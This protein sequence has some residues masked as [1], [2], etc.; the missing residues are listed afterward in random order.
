MRK[1]S[2]KVT[3]N[4][5]LLA[6][7][8]SYKQ[9][10]RKGAVKV[11]LVY[12]NSYEA[13]M[14]SLGFQTLFA[15]INDLENISCERAFY[16]KKPG[17]TVSLESE[18]KLSV[19][20]IV[21]FSISFENDFVNLV[22]LL[23]DAGIPLRSSG[24]SKF[25]PLVIAG[26][27]SCFLNPEPIAP[28][29]DCIL[30]GEAETYLE[31]FFNIYIES[32]SKKDVLKGLAEKLP[33][34]YI[35]SFYE[36]IQVD[37]KYLSSPKPKFSFA[38]PK[39]KVGYVDNLNNYKTTSTI[40]TRNT[41]FK[42][43]FLIETARGCPHGC[44]FCSAGFIYRPPRFYSK[45]NIMESIEKGSQLTK[46]IGFV[47]AAVSD[48][49]DINEICEKALE[50]ELL[51]SFSSFRADLLSKNVLSSIGKSSIKTATIAPEAGSQRMRDIINKNI[52]ED[53]I[54]KCTDYLVDAGI[55]NLKLYFLIG[56]PFETDKDIDE[57]IILIK[58]IK[59][60]FLNASKKKKKIG[61]IS[62]SINPFI[63]K[64]STPFQWHGFTRDK[65][66]KNRM[67]LIKDSLRKVPNVVVKMESLKQSK[68]NSF[69]SRA[70]RRGSD[71]IELAYKQGWAK[72][73]QKNDDYV[74]SVIYET[75]PIDSD[76]PWDIV[77]TGLK[78]SFLINEYKRAEQA[79]TTLP[80][81]IKDCHE[82]KICK[83]TH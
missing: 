77:D 28:F 69:L 74:N 38:D 48:H 42:D 16:N 11:C 53:E 18:T 35:P 81:P 13:G 39:I 59:E 47:S 32:N 82:C 8:Q 80:C 27:F 44:R 70:D 61:T 6:T 54:L 4:R 33:F 25:H 15:L 55:I 66:L 46:K 50:L 40:L 37:Q 83:E 21:A 36:T 41:S 17:S 34:A 73:L 57:I 45:E 9:I 30:F 3:N 12:P 71:Y 63:P 68:I 5:D 52:S 51:P 60:V 65:T 20:D 49:P 62:V 78:K 14:S 26:G 29:M 10:S 67:K 58:K 75:W 24:R 43:T 19:F 1:S 76:L 22:P 64:P 2:K 31:Q 7:E 56:L 23:Q 72:T 79:K